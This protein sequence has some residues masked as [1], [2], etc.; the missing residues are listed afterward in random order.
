MKRSDLKFPMENDLFVKTLKMMWEEGWFDEFSENHFLIRALNGQ[1]P[2]F[3]TKNQMDAVSPELYFHCDTP[4]NFVTNFSQR[5]E[6]FM[7]LCGLENTKRFVDQLSAGKSKYSEDQFFEALHEIHVF[8]YLTSFGDPKVQY[9]PPLGGKSGKKNPE[10]RI[11]NKFAIPSKEPEKPLIP[12]ENYLL[13]IEVKSIVGQVSSGID[14]SKPFI[15]PIVPIDCQKCSQLVTFCDELGFQ[16]ELP[17]ITHLKSF[18]NDAANKFEVPTNENHFNILCLNWTYR[19]IPVLNFMEPLSLLDNSLN[20]L[21]RYK[22]IG[23]NFG[24]N[25]E[26]FEKVSAIFIYSYPK[27]ALAFNDLRWVFANNR[28]AVLFNP[29]LNEKQVLQ[30]TH[31]L[32]IAPSANPHTP[33]MLSYTPVTSMFEALDLSNLD[34]IEEV[35]KKIL[36]KG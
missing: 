3:R 36:F 4:F 28:C 20:G 15:I 22:D 18:L 5:M 35:I 12:I 8:T 23:L 7:C 6:K 10:Y 14:L 31:I 29:K 16:V 17:N 26:A 1:L 2:N 27:Q 33:L 19:E 13:D 9:E 25:E 30:L 21:F 24:L 34:G 11:K 32:H